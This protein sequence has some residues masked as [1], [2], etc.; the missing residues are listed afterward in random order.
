MAHRAAFALATALA[1]GLLAAPPAARAH[2][3]TLDGPVVVDARAALAAGDPTAVL[4]WVRTA[5][6]PEIRA[7]FARAVAVRAGGGEAAAL[8]DTWF[9]ETLVR[10]HRA[11]EGAPFT[12]LKP[13]GAVEPAIAQADRSLAQGSIDEFA[14]RIGAHAKAAVTERF[15]RV[16][17][18]RAHAGESVEKGR[19]Y[20]AAYVEYVHFVEGVV[21]AVH[22]GPAHAAPAAHQH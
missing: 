12:G 3:D 1:L 13:A 8:A 19:E 20:V 10:V 15:D 11:G 17:A 6:E 18:A 2:C 22:R 21:Q 7:A 4:K 16:V 9:F 14:G 5:D